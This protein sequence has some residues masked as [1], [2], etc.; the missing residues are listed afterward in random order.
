MQHKDKFKGI[1][2][3]KHKIGPLVLQRNPFN[4]MHSTFLEVKHKDIQ[5]K[6]LHDIYP[7]MSNLFKW[8][9]KEVEKCNI[10]NIKDDLKHSLFECVIARDSIKNFED[11]LTEYNISI[12]KLTYIDILF[13]TKCTWPVTQTNYELTTNIDTFI[14][15]LKHKLLT[16]RENKRLITKDE[17]KTIIANQNLIEKQFNVCKKMG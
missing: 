9:I 8:K 14:L 16:M 5:F 3:K 13:G 15:I 4:T 11:V 2:R 7:T 6:I 1:P 12:Q 10:C 17:I